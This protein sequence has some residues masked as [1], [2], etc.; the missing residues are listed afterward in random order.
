MNN[1][2]IIRSEAT[3]L[4]DKENSGHGME[5]VNRVANIASNIAQKEKANIELATAIALL[6][7]VDDYKIFGDEY[8]ENLINTKNILEKTTFTEEEKNIVISAMK[9]IG[10][11]KRL[12][13]IVPQSIEAK[14]VSDADMIDAIGAVGLLRSH[15]YNISH[16]RVFFDKDV[17]PE[18]DMDAERYKAK[19]DGTVVTH[20]FEKMLTLKDLMLTES[21]KEEALKRHKFIIE[22]LKEYFY[23]I[24]N[25]EWMDYL[26]EYVRKR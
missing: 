15:Q 19:Q 12:A 9:T 18:L 6:H 8:A 3:K 17:Y 23:E 7:D 2:D 24:D 10:Y 16:N 21:G 11:S 4:L 5:H 1:I 14:V 20:I 26:K 25:K 13:G 22:F